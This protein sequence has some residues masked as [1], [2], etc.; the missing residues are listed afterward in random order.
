MSWQGYPGCITTWQIQEG[1]TLYFITI[2]YHKNS[3]IWRPATTSSKTGPMTSSHSTRSSSQMC[4]CF[5]ATTQVQTS[6]NEPFQDTFKVISKAYPGEAFQAKAQ[7][8]P[9]QG[10]WPSMVGMVHSSSGRQKQDG[11]AANC[12]A[13]LSHRDES[14]Q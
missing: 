8:E 3:L 11:K 6:G 4:H 13:L 1:T 7:Y 5:N 2:H 10:G 9:Q 14:R 12:L